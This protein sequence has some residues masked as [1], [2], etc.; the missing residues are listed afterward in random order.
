MPSRTNLHKILLEAATST[1]RNL[2]A[3][4]ATVIM[5]THPTIS[6]RIKNNSDRT[7]RDVKFLKC[8]SDDVHAGN[9]YGNDEAI[10][11][12]CEGYEDILRHMV[13]SPYTIGY[14]Y[15][16]EQGNIRQIQ[17]LMTIVALDANGN[18]R[19]TPIAFLLDPYQYYQNRRINNTPYRLD[20]TTEICYSTVFPNADILIECVL[21]PQLN[22]AGDVPRYRP[23]QN[24][25]LI[26][27]SPVDTSLYPAMYPNG[28]LVGT[29]PMHSFT[30]RNDNVKTTNISSFTN[31]FLKNAK[32]V[33]S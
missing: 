7:I 6:I 15:A 10:S 5:P 22:P 27:V 8:L 9:N 14:T 3:Q 28:G 33:V 11:I 32:K 24:P 20:A 4:Q 17:Q 23:Y 12:S 21:A 26:R 29:N 30:N 2:Q 25:E 16:E 18:V 13:V 19:S 31:K 1:V